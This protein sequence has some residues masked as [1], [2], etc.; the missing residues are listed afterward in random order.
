MIPLTAPGPGLAA[1]APSASQTDPQRET[2]KALGAT[3]AGVATLLARPVVE[4]EQSLDTRR[5]Q[6]RAPRWGQD[7]R[8]PLLTGPRPAFERTPL[9]HLRRSAL[10]HA[11]DG[12]HPSAPQ[13]QRTSV[14]QV[15]TVPGG[16]PAEP[17]ATLPFTAQRPA[18]Q[19]GP[20]GL[21]VYGTGA[22]T[23]SPGPD[24]TLNMTR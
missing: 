3:A 8:E 9:E 1:T 6:D 10:G 23:G 12:A 15:G 4:A 17:V 2:Q 22:V 7:S 11:E 14:P 24:Q 19:P 20:A 5:P 21:P 16:R 13:T 18:D